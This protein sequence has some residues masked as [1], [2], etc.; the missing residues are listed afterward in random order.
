MDYP[1]SV[2]GV[3]LVSGKFV[4]EDPISGLPGS[5]I[6]AE[7]GNAVTEEILRVI[8]AAGIEPVEGLN[9]QLYKA[10]I[11]LLTARTPAATQERYGLVQLANADETVLGQDDAKVVTPLALSYLTASVARRG[12]VELATQAEAAGGTDSSR[13]VTSVALAGVLPFRNQVRFASPGAFTWP[14]PAGVTKALVTLQG[15]GGG[16][17]GAF[18]PAG[19]GAVGGGGGSGA[20]GMRL[21]D[22]TGVSSV[23][24]VV[25]SGGVGGVSNTSASTAGTA[26][27]F[28]A[29]LSAS[30]AAGGAVGFGG[31]G[32]G[33][34]GGGTVTGHE[35]G[36]NGMAGM[37]GSIRDGV[38]AA[39]GIGA[40]SSFGGCTNAPNVTGNGNAGVNGNAG[41][42]GSGGSGGSAFGATAAGGAGGAGFVLIQW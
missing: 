38:Y 20:W 34:A 8:L 29:Y 1:K 10:I 4:N 6:P 41:N 21:V 15:A 5:L 27:S 36:G 7:W 33:G 22:L 2:P 19:S 31:P 12:L 17:G 9:D 18:A 42:N 32:V 35:F 3:G 16:G 39:S 30:G 25:G 14:V 40:P 23:S 24:G 37:I 11:N 28:G 13:A 26:S